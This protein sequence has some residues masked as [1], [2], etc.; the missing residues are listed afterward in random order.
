ME[1]AEI[2]EMTVQY[3]SQLH[4]AKFRSPWSDVIAGAPRLKTPHSRV[5]N[6]LQEFD[7]SSSSEYRAGFNEC[8]I[9]VQRF[10][11]DRAEASISDVALPQL[12]VSHM[13]QL[14]GDA[15][16]PNDKDLV[17]RS[18]PPSPDTTLGALSSSDPAPLTPMPSTSTAIEVRSSLA[19][20]SSLVADQTSTS[21]GHHATLPSFLLPLSAALRRDQFIG[22]VGVKLERTSSPEYATQ[23][24]NSTVFVTPSSAITQPSASSSISLSRPSISMSVSAECDNAAATCLLPASPSNTDHD[25]WR[26]W[27]QETTTTCCFRSS[28]VSDSS[29]AS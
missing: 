7:W 11:A 15:S 3:I 25:V 10:L 17:V 14:F 22:N 18:S 16:R 12:L 9:H 6:N 20:S 29:S 27:R 19:R 8:L 28:D 21:F 24:L 2:L 13:N 1:K 5:R 23:H 26:P 4:G